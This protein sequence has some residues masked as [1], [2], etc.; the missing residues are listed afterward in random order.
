M[1]Q[2]LEFLRK[3]RKTDKPLSPNQ[4]KVKE[5]RLKLTNLEMKGKTDITTHNEEIQRIMRP[6]FKISTNQK[7]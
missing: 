4:P 5:R 7:F 3:V 1:K 6:Y 2:S